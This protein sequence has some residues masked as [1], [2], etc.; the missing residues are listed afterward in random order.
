[1]FHFGVRIIFHNIFRSMRNFLKLQCLDD[2]LYE[3]DM[4]PGYDKKFFCNK[5][6]TRF[7]IRKSFI[8]K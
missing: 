1:M 7:F 4:M 3:V 5:S 8:R 6:L 2:D